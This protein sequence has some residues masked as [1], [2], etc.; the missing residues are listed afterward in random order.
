MAVDTIVIYKDETLLISPTLR[1][2]HYAVLGLEVA[3]LL[4]L[5]AHGSVQQ[6]VWDYVRY[7][8]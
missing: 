7:N 3:A 2:T 1:S 4:M 6:R 5:S 8:G